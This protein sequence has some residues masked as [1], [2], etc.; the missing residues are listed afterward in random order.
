MLN[1]F[2]ARLCAGETT[3]LPDY[4]YRN[5]IDAESLSCFLLELLDREDAAG[6]FHVGATEAISRFELGMRLAEK[7]GF[8]R[9]SGP[10]TNATAAR[11]RRPGSGSF[12]S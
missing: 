12:P 5:P 6:I 8:S 7:M 9:E 3:S 11:A 10:C 4:E 1:K 2:A